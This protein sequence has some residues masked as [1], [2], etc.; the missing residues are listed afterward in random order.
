MS[1][2]DL[3]EQNLLPPLATRE[4]TETFGESLNHTFSIFRIHPLR[5][6]LLNQGVD[7]LVNFCT[8]YSPLAPLVVLKDQLR[9]RLVSILKQLLLSQS[10]FRAESDLLTYFL[11]YEHDL[12]FRTLQSQHA[13]TFYSLLLFVRQFADFLDHFFALERLKGLEEQQADAFG[14]ITYLKHFKFKAFSFE[15]FITVRAFIAL[16]RIGAIF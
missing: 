15:F 11:N 4:L 5:E 13:L 3:I 6:D 2:I 9:P 12:V 16:S 10:E 7:Y 14:P 8:A 1:A